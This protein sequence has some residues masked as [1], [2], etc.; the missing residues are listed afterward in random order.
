MGKEKKG[1]FLSK[2]ISSIKE[3]ILVFCKN[4]ELFN[5]LIAEIN[6]EEE[7]YPCI[8]ASNKRSIIKIPKGIIS[9]FSKKNYFLPKGEKISVSTMDLIL[10]SDLVINESR[11]AQDLL[12]EGNWRYK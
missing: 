6:E 1:T 8:N 10:H 7:T 11:L 5:G 9:K 12:I 4:R 2:S 3:Y